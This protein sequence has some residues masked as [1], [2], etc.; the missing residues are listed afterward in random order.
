MSVRPW[1][2]MT[3]ADIARK[4]DRCVEK[5][6]HATDVLHK[7]LLGLTY[8]TEL[9]EWLEILHKMPPESETPAN[10]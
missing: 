7:P 6:D 8:Q 5:R 1:P 3:R 9:E 2:G 10:D 4:I